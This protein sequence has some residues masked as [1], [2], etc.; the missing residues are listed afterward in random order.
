MIQI[1]A[2]VQELLMLIVFSI[3]FIY[4]EERALKPED[5][6]K[7][8]A[9]IFSQHIYKK[10]ISAEIIQNS[11]HVYIDQ[12]DPNRIYLLESEVRSFIDLNKNDAGRILRQYQ[13][14]EFV[15]YKRL[16]T[17]IQVAIHRAR[18]YRESLIHHHEFAFSPANS[19]ADYKEHADYHGFA[20]NPVELKQR[21]KQRMQDFIDMEIVRVGV[22]KVKANKDKILQVYDLFMRENERQY[23]FTDKN[24]SLLAVNERD[25]LFYMHTIK[26]LAK[27]LDAH[28]SFFNESEAYD[29]R[30]LLEKGFD[31]VGIVLAK[32][33]FGYRVAKLLPNSTAEKSREIQVGDYLLRI[34]GKSI[35]D[36]SLSDIMRSLRGKRGTSISLQLKRERDKQQELPKPLYYTVVIKRESIVVNEGRAEVSAF[37]FGDGFIGSIKLLSFYQGTNGISSDQDVRNAIKKLEKRGKLKGLIL[38]L[39]ENSGGFLTQAVKVAG[40]F[41]TNGVIVVSK[42]SNGEKRY[43]RDMDG[44]VSYKGPLIVLTSRAT[45]S[46]AE[47][48]AQALQDYGVALVV[49]DEQTYGKG[50]IQSQ[51]VT[52]DDQ[53]GSYFKVTVGK[54]YTVSGKTPQVEGVKADIVVPSPYSLE[55]LGEEYL[56]YPV[57][58]DTIASSYE[59]TLSDIDPGLRPWYLRYYIPT[60][61]QK[62]QFWNTFLPLLRRNSRNR[63]INSKV[64]HDYLE[65]A[66]FDEEHG[67]RADQI[68]NFFGNQ[69]PQLREAVEVV[70]DMVIMEGKARNNQKIGMTDVNLLSER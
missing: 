57:S 24:E 53:K 19:P 47:I 44:K 18:E 65:K 26:A 34:N 56:E 39:R 59:D 48:V 64:Y 35:E 27:S 3:S 37:K 22:E 46:A 8:M 2:L 13:N 10:E 54:Y 52:D 15:A 66:R 5:V 12:F 31:G 67:Y 32:D 20:K 51:T 40:L 33:P 43:Y 29:M 16:N 28:T 30:V 50:T 9:Q 14:N 6:K 41:V 70:K 11:F 23:L 42:Y 55:Q 7:V 49:G 36:R 62:S 45:A 63:L 38:D 58:Q 25:N 17:L 61:Q 21:Q 4:A 1:K 60:L 68:I 69:D